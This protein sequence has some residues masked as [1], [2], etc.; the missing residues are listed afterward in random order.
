MQLKSQSQ[1]LTF[2]DRSFVLNHE[3]EERKTYWLKGGPNNLIYMELTYT[4]DFG[5]LWF[6]EYSRGNKTIFIGSTRAEICSMMSP[7]MVHS[8]SESAYLKMKKCVNKYCMGKFGR[9]AL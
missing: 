1:L 8:T 4:P 9:A 3:L 6:A 2:D 5:W 7:K